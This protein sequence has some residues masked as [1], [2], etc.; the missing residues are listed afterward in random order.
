MAGRFALTILAFA[1]GGL[2][3][4]AGPLAR[5]AAQDTSGAVGQRF[6]V[7][8]PPFEP[9]Q[10]ADND[11]GKDAAERL[12][13]LL[14]GLAT[15]QP[16]EEKEIKDSAKRFKLDWEEL[17]CAHTRQLAGEIH[18]QVA[19]CADYHDQA[20]KRKAVNATF[21]DVAS[22]ESFEVEPRTFGEKQADSAAVYI[23]RSFDTYVQQVSAA[24]Y[25]NV[26][27]QSKDFENAMEKCDQS[28]E[29]N[30]NAVGSRYTRA[31]IL[32]QQEKYD[33]AMQ[34]LGRILDRDPGNLDALSLSGYISATQGKDE[35]A[36][37]FYEKYLALNPSD[38]QV[39]MKIA[40]DL[41]RAGDPVG[42]MQ[43]IQVGLDVEP[44]NVDLL[45]Q[46]AGFA[47][48]AALEADRG[49]TEGDDSAAVPAESVKYYHEAVQAGEKVFAARGEETSVVLLR[50]SI[51]AYL[52][53]GEVDRALELAQQAVKV[54]AGEDQ[55]WSAYANALHDAGRLDDAITALDSAKRIN[56]TDANHGLRQASWLIQAGRL[57]DAVEM[58][59]SNAARGQQEADRAAQMIFGD[60]YNNGIKKEKFDYAS[61]ALERARQ[62]PN[63]SAEMRHQLT[64]WEA[65]AIYQGA[66][67]GQKPQTLATAR[68][69]LPKFQRALELLNDVGS[70]PQT[71]KVD[72]DQMKAN[73][74]QYVEIQQAILKRGG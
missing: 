4:P 32:F 40:Y 17:D 31:N 28:I 53:L 54:H 47:F 35:E 49:A 13:E 72:L 19:L 7:L 12:R 61:E 8:V 59:R 43:I 1:V 66:V 16:V 14:N 38:V 48:N 36:R 68:A 70:Y 24:R 23:F 64:F 56:P 29:L 6:R 2:L 3:M 25:C 27:A 39:R 30:P 5:L 26:Y 37:A 11:F 67:A 21:Y 50:N 20:D 71:V 33:E 62:L 34:E 69:T 63:L 52:K 44:D 60:A 51:A 41:A 9:K 10:G 65:Y 58:L 45:E 46:Y 74:G 42:A 22:D 18:A 73:C 55:I 57:T 15:H